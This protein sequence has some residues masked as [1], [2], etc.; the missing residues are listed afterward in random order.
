MLATVAATTSS[1][2]SMDQARRKLKRARVLV[3][4][5]LGLEAL[6]QRDVCRGRPD[7]IDGD[8]GGGRG[9]VT[10][11]SQHPRHPPQSTPAH[12]HR[13]LQPN[14][15]RN[16]P[17]TSS[18]SGRFR[19]AAAASVAMRTAP[20]RA[21]A[22]WRHRRQ[23]LE[24]V[25]PQLYE[26]GPVRRRVPV[27]H[28]RVSVRGALVQVLVRSQAPHRRTPLPPSGYAM[29]SAPA[30]AQPQTSQQE[31]TSASNSCAVPWNMNSPSARQPTSPLIAS[32]RSTRTRRRSVPGAASASPIS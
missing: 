29:V 14:H 26:D 10:D 3:G 24:L 15:R 30:P 32:P 6:A 8:G 2:S 18:A 12:Y 31:P 1:S 21:V 9:G 20:R 27:V 11:D 5:V 28:E 22:E 13:F 23:P 7:D 16:A 17:N 25:R 4:E 19:R